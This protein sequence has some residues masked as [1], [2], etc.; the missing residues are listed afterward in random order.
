[1]SL[2]RIQPAHL[3]KIQPARTPCENSARFE[4]SRR[5]ALTGVFNRRYLDA[6][7]T[8]ELQRSQ[9]RHQPLTVMLLNIDH[10]KRIN[11]ELG[12]VVGDECLLRL[13][14]VAARSCHRGGDFVARCG[15]DELDI[16]LP[17][18]EHLGALVWARL[19]GHPFR[20][21]SQWGIFCLEV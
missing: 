9:R 16:V 7:L 1:M 17:D 4:E 13:A 10:F 21:K 19:S 5:D 14:T 18:T 8:Q 6:Q 3:L 20:H 11:D 15:G 12:H 2:V